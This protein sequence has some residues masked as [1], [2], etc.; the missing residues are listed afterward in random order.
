VLIVLLVLITAIGLGYSTFSYSLV[1]DSPSRI[2]GETLQVNGYTIL[3][4]L[5]FYYIYTKIITNNQTYTLNTF[6]QLK[7]NINN[8]ITR[9]IS[10]DFEE[11]QFDDQKYYIT[12]VMFGDYFVDSLNHIEFNISHIDPDTLYTKSSDYEY[13]TLT[14]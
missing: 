7:P 5:D 13:K 8:L 9:P 4:P 1:S 11:T 6:K 14:E 12:A 3:L 10:L 2:L